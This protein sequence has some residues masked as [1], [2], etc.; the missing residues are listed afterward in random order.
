MRF[1]SPRAA[2]T[3]ARLTQT[4]LTQT[5]LTQT[6][7]TQARLAQARLTQARRRHGGR[8]AVAQLGA[9]RGLTCLT[10]SCACAGLLRPAVL[11]RE[12]AWAEHVRAVRRPRPVASAGPA[13]EEA[14][15]G[16]RSDFCQSS[17]WSA[18]TT[19]GSQRPA[20]ALDGSCVSRRASLHG[21]LAWVSLAWVSLV[22]VKLVWVSLV[23]VS[24]AWVSLV[25]VRVPWVRRAWVRLVVFYI[26]SRSVELREVDMNAVSDQFQR[27]SRRGRRP[28]L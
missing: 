15:V 1:G 18:T 6:R 19:P 12:R 27:T 23:W 25:W 9:G 22:W 4:S 20:A 17:A 14:D 10:A 8:A 11:P 24:L 2:L 26:W 5:R 28:A 13:E 3:Q 21:S 16:R 7:L